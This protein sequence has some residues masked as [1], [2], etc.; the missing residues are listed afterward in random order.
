MRRVVV[1]GATGTMGV[2]LTA[3]LRRR[4]DH[5]V[6]LSRDARGGRE[7]LGDGV[8]VHEW[9]DPTRV[10]PPAEALAGADAVVHLLGEPVAQRWIRDSRVLGTRALVG[11]LRALPGDERPR[12]LVS[13][14][15]TGFYGPCDARPLDEEA[16][17]GDG[18]LAELVA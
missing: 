15:A 17:A 2:A 8:E 16:P 13:Q 14:S 6:A 1:T 4:G 5:V 9:A 7:R 18:F 11:A 3:A 12:A 10:D